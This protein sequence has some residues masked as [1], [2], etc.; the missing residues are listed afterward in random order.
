[1]AITKI[2]TGG[3]PAL[4]VT[5][6]KLHTTM[7]LSGKTVTLPTLTALDVTNNIVVGGTVDGIDIAA[8]DAVLTSTATTAAAALPKAGGTM[9]GALAINSGTANTGLTITSTDAASWLTMTDPTASLFFGNT[10]GEFAL[11]TGGAEALRINS[12]GNV[13]IRTSSIAGVADSTGVQSVQLGGTHLIHYDEDAAGTSSFSNNVYWNGSQNTTVF[14]GK[15]SQ[16]Y[17][18]NG[19]IIFRNS[20]DNH[21]AGAQVANFH[22]RMRIDSSGNVGIGET[23]PLGKLHVKTADSGATAD[24]GADELIIEGSGNVGMSILS[25]ASNTGSIYFG[26][27]GT[28]WDGYIAYSQ[29]SRSMTLG[30]AAGGGSVNITSSGNVGIGAT[31]PG[32]SKLYL[33]DTHTTTV[34]NA[35]TMIANTTL[36]INGNSGQGSDVIRMGPMGTAGR[37]FIDVSNSAGTAAYDLLLNPIGLG[38][39]GINTP[40]P[41]APLHIRQNTSDAYTATNYNNVPTL[42]LQSN[43]A[44]TNYSGIR[45]TN[46]VGNYE[47]F[48][49][50]VQVSSNSAD[51][52]FQGHDRAT[53]T[54]KEY[55]R[56]YDNGRV[57]FSQMPNFASRPTYTN[58]ELG[59]GAV[60]S[61]NNPH[62]DT[63]NDF[64]GSTN[65]FTAP[66][67][68]A[69]RFDFHSNIWKNAVGIMYF[70]W[71]KNGA[72]TSGTQGGRIY[73]Y[74]AGGWENMC[75]FVVI[76]LAANDYVDLRA[77]GGG[78]K[79]DGNSYGQLTGYML[80]SA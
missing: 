4:A 79:V 14:S 62:V 16:I 69:Y 29:S 33:Q 1:M 11:W 25:G 19:N 21:G 20:D 34:T 18:E 64:S 37:Q 59:A 35:T 73:G 9:T 50:A 55:L 30:T 23:S 31:N 52:V 71:F 68:G 36:T 15:G 6:D 70:N 38:N 13:G 49:G 66:I 26:D 47:S 2:Q 72:D 78:P 39:V 46:S 65:R 3:I 41:S 12:S 22:E 8:R 5:H 7:D 74:Y 61:F 63:G 43:N 17:M 48:I 75:G 28:N 56:V 80:T 53:G 76:N 42:T 58:I 24:A 32:G 67:A 77:G 10:G 27:S 45:L 57:A 40:S 44:V 51:M 54:Y 60:V